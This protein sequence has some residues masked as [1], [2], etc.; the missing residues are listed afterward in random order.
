VAASIDADA[1]TERR[2]G[3]LSMNKE[4]FGVFGDRDAFDRFQGERSFDAVLEGERAT[5]GIRSPVLGVPG[6][7]SVH[8][9]EAGACALFGEAFLDGDGEDTARRLRDRYAE[10]GDAALDDLSGSYVAFLEA[11][12]RPLVSTDPIRSWECYYADVDGVRTFSTDVSA[13][14][15]LV[16]DPVPNRQAVLEMLHLGTVLGENTLFEEIDRAPVD[17]YLTGSGVETLDRFV[18]EPREFDYVQ[19]LATRLRRALRR[20]RFY[21]GRKGLLLSGGKDSRLFLSQ[22]PDIQSTYTIGSADSREV[23]V[24][25]KIARQYDASHTA[26]E[27]G[28]R[29]LAPS[30]RKL[31]YSQGIKEALHI[32]H[33]GYDDELQADVMYHGLLFDTLFKG[34]FLERDGLTVFGSKLPSRNLVDDPDPVESLLD[35]LGYLP[36]GSRRVAEVADSL[37]EEVDLEIGSPRAFLRR[38]LEAEL[39]RCWSRATSTHNAMDLL[40]IRNQPVMPF[41][42]HLADNYVESFVT[43]DRELLAWHLQT[44]PAHRHPDTFRRALERID[45]EL[46]RHRPPSQPH[47]STYLNQFERFVR[48]KTPFVEAFEPAWPSR[49][50]IY[51]RHRMDEQLFPEHAA[52]RE[53]PPRQKLR[54]ND[55]RWWLS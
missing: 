20:R 39:E 49:Q 28:S 25:R 47:R 34:Y 3:G 23:G 33:A 50:D 21:P 51:E 45:D 19:E 9:D 43:M 41:H 13:L 16:D 52:I 10:V 29:Y 30:D 31:L 44:P 24:A 42:V 7:S 8:A 27:P 48:R 17:S 5:V 55:A 36:D 1:E 54:V 22:V 4:L 18:Y 35:T 46:L 26:L 2:A 14:K 32:H 6:R 12:G 40:V 37:F 11:D 15:R 38:R 53:L